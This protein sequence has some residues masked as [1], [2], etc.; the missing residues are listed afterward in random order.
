MINNTN[1]TERLRSLIEK[2]I[3]ARSTFLWTETPKDFTLISI[4]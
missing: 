2:V 3:V 4:R 1:I